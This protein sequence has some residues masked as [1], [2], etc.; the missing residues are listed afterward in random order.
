MAILSWVSQRALWLCLISSTSLYCRSRLGSW[1]AR[2]AWQAQRGV[3]QSSW[4]LNHHRECAATFP[5]ATIYA[6]CSCKATF[7][8]ATLLRWPRTSPLG[9]DP[10]DAGHPTSHMHTGGRMHECSDK[11]RTLAGRHQVQVPDV[12]FPKHG[13]TFCPRLC[14][15]MMLSRGGTRWSTVR[16][17]VVINSAVPQGW[18]M[19]RLRLKGR[20]FMISS[21]SCSA[22]SSEIMRNNWTALNLSPS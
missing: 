3:R 13:P 4:R 22:E 8:L 15:G 10:Q 16:A 17:N 11:S 18:D 2:E 9:A 21:E 5:Q 14:S 7:V 1:G 6:L 12:V 19:G 20:R